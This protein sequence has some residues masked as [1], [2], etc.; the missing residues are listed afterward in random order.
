MASGRPG[1]VH[2][3]GVEFF[4]VLSG[5]IMVLIHRKDFG[6]AEQVSQF[7]S[8]RITRIYPL[9]WIIFAALTVCYFLAPKFG[10]PLARDPQAIASSFVLWPMPYKPIM[11]MAWTLRHEMLFYLI[12]AVAI[13]NRRLGL[14]LLAAWVFACV[15]V[16][17]ALKWVYPW[18]FLFADYNILFFVGMVA[19]L[20]CHRLSGRGAVA[21]LLVG[22]GA[23]LATGLSEAYHLIVWDHALRTVCYGLAAM[24]IVTGLASSA[25]KPPRWLTFLGDASYSI[26]LSHMAAM[27][28]GGSILKKIGAPSHL[29]PTVTIFVL[30]AIVAAAGS[31]VHLFVERPT[32]RLFRHRRNPTVAA[33]LGAS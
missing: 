2:Y 6:R 7:I 11:E 25:I 15:V 33:E 22:G 5:F 14:A 3:S 4:F 13:F 21:C 1:A 8:K 26:Y 29:P 32:L 28:V 12:F 16:S 17:F 24:L 20:F 10:P 19:G 30:L 9:Y 23:Y 27:A 31:A 18:D